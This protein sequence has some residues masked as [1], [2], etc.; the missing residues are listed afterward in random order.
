MYDVTDGVVVPGSVKF[1]KVTD[2]EIA[3]QTG[4]EDVKVNGGTWVPDTAS[5]EVE[6][7]PIEAPGQE[8]PTIE[9]AMEVTPD[10]ASAEEAAKEA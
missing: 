5:F 9:V 10:K 3:D 1:D 2:E 4:I 8:K 6:P 7:D